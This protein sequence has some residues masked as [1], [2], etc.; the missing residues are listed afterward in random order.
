L[1]E[2]FRRLDEHHQK[3]RVSH[4]EG[5]FRDY[6]PMALKN[7]QLAHLVHAGVCN[8]D[9]V[10]SLVAGRYNYGAPRIVVANVNDDG[11][12]WLEHEPTDLGPLD[13]KY[14]EKTLEYL[15]EL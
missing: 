3:H 4:W 11:S 2:I 8:E 12:L 15:H 6:L 13:F 1:D 5:T 7:P 14:A 9:V 10:Y